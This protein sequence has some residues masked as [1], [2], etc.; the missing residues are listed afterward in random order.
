MLGFFETRHAEKTRGWKGLSDSEK[1]SLR[2]HMLLQR[3]GKPEEVVKAILFMIKDADY[4]TGSVVRL[5]G[6]YVVGGEQVPDMPVGLL[7]S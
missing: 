6:G 1:K 3:T 4:M 5:D 7:D 2:N